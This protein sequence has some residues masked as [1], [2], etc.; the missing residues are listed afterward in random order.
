MRSPLSPGGH[1]V[2]RWH[3]VLELRHP[4]YADAFFRAGSVS[5]PER[6]QKRFREPVCT[7]ARVKSGKLRAV[8][9]RRTQQLISIRRP[10]AGTATI[11]DYAPPRRPDKIPECSECTAYRLKSR[12]TRVA[13]AVKWS[14]RQTRVLA[15]LF[16]RLTR[17]KTAGKLFWSPSVLRTR[18]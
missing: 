9:P 8:N 7:Q 3:A 4:H 11:Q 6:A 12:G 16:G 2:F 17:A 1:S 5:L 14:G 10:I 18:H 13:W 15:G